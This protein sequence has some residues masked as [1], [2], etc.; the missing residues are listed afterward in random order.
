MAARKVARLDRQS[1]YVIT[2]SIE[3]LSDKSG[4]PGY[5]GKLRESNVTG[6]EYTL[7][8]SG[9]SPHKPGHKNINCTNE[10]RRELAGIIY[11]SR[12]GIT[13]PLVVVVAE[14]A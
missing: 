12:T 11:V 10:L 5:V 3:T 2:T 9:K 14:I 13:L 7:Y 8:D 4:G 1:E 6:T